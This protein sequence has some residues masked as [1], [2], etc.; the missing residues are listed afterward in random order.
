MYTLTFCAKVFD[1]AEDL[2]GGI[3]KGDCPLS[4]DV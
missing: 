3:A 2:E 4:L 1:V